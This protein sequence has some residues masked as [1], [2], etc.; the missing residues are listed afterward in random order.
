LNSLILFLLILAT[1]DRAE[2]GEFRAFDRD[3]EFFL[4]APHG[5]FD[6]KTWKIAEDVCEQIEW[7]CLIATRYRTRETP[8]NVN[9]PSEGIGLGPDE[10]VRSERAKEVYRNYL[11]EIKKIRAKEIRLYIEIHG[12]VRI[13]SD[14]RLEIASKGLQ[15]DQLKLVKKIIASALA[16]QGL[17]NIK[18]WVEPLDPIFFT[19]SANKRFGMMSTLP[20][21]LHIEIPSR[22]RKFVPQRT[23]L[24]KA[25]AKALPEIE[26]N[27]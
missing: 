13:E 18:V 15:T 9:R 22:L 5:S 19:A 24:I 16:E 27:L 6:T 7:D 25:L 11:E 14:G 2:A 21:A 23:R 26:K 12:N 4:S 10:E 8:I 3:S 1:P 20:R 17:A